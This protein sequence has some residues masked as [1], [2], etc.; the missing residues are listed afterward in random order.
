M[1][2]HTHTTTTTILWLS[3][4]CRGLPGWAGTRRNIHPL[5]LLIVNLLFE[6]YDIFHVLRT[7][8]HKF[9]GWL[10]GWIMCSHSTSNLPVPADASHQAESESVVLQ[11]GDGSVADETDKLSH[12]HTDHSNNVQ[13]CTS[14]HWQH[15]LL[16]SRYTC[17]VIT[18]IYCTV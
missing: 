12:E 6:Y 8:F 14:A 4:F 5:K 17:C 9:V 2:A 3:G 11:L 1:H 18:S 16:L 7:W 15:Q 10:N 13:V